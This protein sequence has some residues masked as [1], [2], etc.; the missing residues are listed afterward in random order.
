MLLF[1]LDL[2]ML[3][4][5]FPSFHLPPS[6][7]APGPAQKIRSKRGCGE[8]S[9]SPFLNTDANSRSLPPVSFSDF[10]RGCL[11]AGSFRIKLEIGNGL[12]EPLGKVIHPRVEHL[13]MR[14]CG[15]E[16]R[17]LSWRTWGFN[18]HLLFFFL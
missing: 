16:G 12:T 4:E 17:F 2:R 7:L 15:R 1:S 11:E 9:N 3:W 10:L 18:A 8:V 5:A 14:F 13:G 6:V